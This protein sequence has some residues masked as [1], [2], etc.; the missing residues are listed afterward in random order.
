GH[1]SLSEDK[2]V[3]YETLY[4]CLMVTAQLMAPIAPF[5]SE[6]LYKN[7][8]DNIRDKAI[9]NKTPL[10]FPSVHLTDLVKAEDHLTDAALE[11]SM[12]YAQRI[13]SL[14]HSIRKNTRIKV[15]TPLQK[16]LLPVLDPAF[17]EQ[18]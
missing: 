9:A 8:T 17:A 14:V 3:A 6:W 5:F 13:C 16:I 4:Y 12:D 2:K 11:K 15:R 18:I 1:T 7:L 10:R